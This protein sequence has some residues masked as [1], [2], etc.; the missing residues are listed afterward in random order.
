V[1]SS[2]NFL[3]PPDVLCGEREACVKASASPTLRK[4]HT[5]VQCQKA[6][7]NESFSR[8]KKLGVPVSCIDSASM[9]GSCDEP[10]LIPN[11]LSF[12][13]ENP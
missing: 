12:S 6:C 4:H 2:L 9:T 5:H 10:T 11:L 7:H 13:R 3:E 1:E 8:K